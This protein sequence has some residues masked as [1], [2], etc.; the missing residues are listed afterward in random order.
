MISNE[1]TT[2]SEITRD[3]ISEFQTKNIVWVYDDIIDAIPMPPPAAPS[4]PTPPPA[5]RPPPSRSALLTAKYKLKRK[6]LKPVS[7][8]PTLGSVLSSIKISQIINVTIYLE[9]SI[10]Y[11]SIFNKNG[12][13]IKYH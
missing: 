9:K 10:F 3:I 4:P 8:T 13:D 6:I 1:T 12:I 7:I 5:P 2:L 11:Y